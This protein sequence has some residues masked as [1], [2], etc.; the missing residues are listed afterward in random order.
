MP[1]M[2]NLLKYAEYYNVINPFK[3]SNLFFIAVYLWIHGPATN[4]VP[5]D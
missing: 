5:M 2:L 4:D 1:K 3:F